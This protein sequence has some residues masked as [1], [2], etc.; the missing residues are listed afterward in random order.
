MEKYT[1]EGRLAYRADINHRI[2]SKNNWKSGFGFDL[3]MTQMNTTYKNTVLNDFSGNSGL[4]KA[5]TQ[6][7]HYFHRSFFMTAGIHGQYYVL[8]S[9]Y[10]VEP[11]LGFKW[12]LTDVS[13]ISLALGLY[14]QLQPR[15]AYFYKDAGELK[16]K[17]LKKTKSWKR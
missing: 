6:W 17:S 8:N 16:N 4:L 11:R 14:S 9:D 10:S 2:S 7:Q 13:S 15:R 1:H 5:Y 3:F 12:N